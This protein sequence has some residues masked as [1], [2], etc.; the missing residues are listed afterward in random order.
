MLE[1]HHLARTPSRDLILA[2]NG[3]L[4]A[5]VALHEAHPPR[6]ETGEDVG[7]DA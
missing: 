1:T 4:G 5:S 7:V 6:S 2:G 3:Q